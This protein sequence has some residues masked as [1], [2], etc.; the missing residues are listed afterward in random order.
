M[1]VYETA[2]QEGRTWLVNTDTGTRTQ[3]IRRN[4]E[5][6]A[7][8]TSF[9]AIVDTESGVRTGWRTTHIDSD[10]RDF[11]AASVADAP[12][13]PSGPVY[14]PPV[15]PEPY[16][17]MGSAE[18][19]GIVAQAPTDWGQIS[20]DTAEAAADA[21]ADYYDLNTTPTVPVWSPDAGSTDWWSDQD[22]SI[23]PV[24]TWEQRG[25]DLNSD[26]G[27]GPTTVP[28]FGF[29]LPEPRD[30]EQ[31]SWGEIGQD[32]SGNQAIRDRV[33]KPDVSYPDSLP[34]DRIQIFGWTPPPF[35]Q[36]GLELV[37]DVLA[38]PLPG[39]QFGTELVG[40]AVSSVV[41]PIFQPFATVAQGIGDIQDIIWL[42]ALLGDED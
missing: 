37:D 34:A 32:F 30:W 27:L 16:A 6:V 2:D 25:T 13:P 28:G 21:Y 8:E 11:A 17:W 14:S 7:S 33:V 38:G 19:E 10:T 1:V 42:M 39:A 26:Y 40:G 41:E 3:V 36:S 4:G 23:A 20:E 12:I 5:L 22:T 24:L 29:G 31:F 15:T 9:K 18:E 35:V